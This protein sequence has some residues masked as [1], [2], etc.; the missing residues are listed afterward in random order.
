MLSDCS[1]H[2]QKV[3]LCEL[4]GFVCLHETGKH[5]NRDDGPETTRASPRCDDNTYSNMV[6]LH[7]EDGHGA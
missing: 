7:K 1:V 5:D 2:S 3:G 4:A 6:D